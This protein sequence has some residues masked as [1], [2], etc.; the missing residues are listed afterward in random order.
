MLEYAVV[1]LRR[2]LGGPVG[3]QSYTVPE[4]ATLAGT[5]SAA[6]VVAFITST[7]LLVIGFIG[8]CVR[9]CQ[10]KGVPTDATPLTVGD[11][12]DGA[13]EV[14]NSFSPVASQV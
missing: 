4:T 1:E 13:H 8:L 10:H 7:M 5:W 11:N 2:S 12:P 9:R 14:V 3:W 6:A